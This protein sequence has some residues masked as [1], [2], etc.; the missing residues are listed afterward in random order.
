M[1]GATAAD[2]PALSQPASYST[3][4]YLKDASGYAEDRKLSPRRR[5]AS[6]ASASPSR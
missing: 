2:E 6:S 1:A 5:S 3:Q 4:L